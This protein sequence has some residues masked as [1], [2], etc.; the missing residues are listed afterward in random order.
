MRETWYI[1]GP[2]TWRPQFNFPLFDRVA[3]EMREAGYTVISPAELDDPAVRVVALESADGDPDP[4]QR[5][6]RSTW[7]D[8]LSRDVKIITEQVTGIVLLPEWRISRGARLEA[9]VGLLAQHKFAKWD[10][11]D[12]YTIHSAHVRK[13]VV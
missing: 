12:L 13:C 7:A 8:Y 3:R 10:S 2:M 5:A 1:A 9:F 11:P 6:T 4:Y